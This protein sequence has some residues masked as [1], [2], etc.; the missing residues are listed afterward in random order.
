[1][2]SFNPDTTLWHILL[3]FEQTNQGSRLLKRD[4]ILLLNIAG[5][6]LTNRHGIPPPEKSALFTLHIHRKGHHSSAKIY[7]HFV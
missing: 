2:A 6:E 4:S 3:H 5:L 7:L 1:V